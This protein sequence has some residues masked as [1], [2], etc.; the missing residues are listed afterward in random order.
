MNNNIPSTRIENLASKKVIAARRING[1]VFDESVHSVNHDGAGEANAGVGVL[2]DK[3]RSGI[4]VGN[5]GTEE[6]H[7]IAK[8][9]GG[10]PGAA[11]TDAISW[12]GS[13]AAR[14]SYAA[15]IAEAFIDCCSIG[16]VPRLASNRD[17]EGRNLLGNFLINQGSRFTLVAKVK[18]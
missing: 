12:A 4:G 5:K 14:C 17:A 6:A 15:E 11:D 16:V 18:A 13:S 8:R 10:Q 3:V 9:D 2:Q 1:A 7:I